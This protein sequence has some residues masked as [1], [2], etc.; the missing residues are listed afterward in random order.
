MDAALD[1]DCWVRGVDRAE[2]YSE[3]AGVP[4]AL[5]LV[6]CSAETVALGEAAALSVRS[7]DSSD[8]DLLAL[9]ELD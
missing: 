3:G 8:I 4:R 7:S 5:A 1:W 9:L 2:E 6:A